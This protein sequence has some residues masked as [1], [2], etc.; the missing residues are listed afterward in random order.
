MEKSKIETQK[1]NIERLRN[2]YKEKK[3]DLFYKGIADDRQKEIIDHITKKRRL[4]TEA[5]MKKKTYEELDE[6]YKRLYTEFDDN[7]PHYEER[8]AKANEQQMDLEV[9]NRYLV[10]RDRLDPKRPE[11]NLQLITMWSEVANNFDDKDI[12]R[13]RKYHEEKLNRYRNRK[14]WEAWVEED[15]LDIEGERILAEIKNYRSEF[16]FN[17]S[18]L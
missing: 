18:V 11:K 3:P 9:M 17:F 13:I 4:F 5:E 6:E 7:Y 2:E 14:D 15:E 10:D 12:A 8:R 1:R 16:F